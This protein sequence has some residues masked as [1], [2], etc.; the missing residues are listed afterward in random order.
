MFF[1]YKVDNSVI[2]VSNSSAPT[3]AL[4]RAFRIFIT[5]QF[6]YLMARQNSI[7][8]F[9]GKLGNMIGYYR[10]GRYLLRS[11]PVS[12]RQTNATRRA[13]QRFG[14]ASKKGALIRS[15]FDSEL[16]IHYDGTHVNR[17]NS[18]LIRAT[19]SSIS[20][21]TGFRFNQHTGIDRFLTIAPVLTQDA[22]LHIP[23]QHLSAGKGITALEVKIIATRISF[24][25]QRVI[26]TNTTT[27]S[28][29]PNRPL[30]ATALSVDVPGTG[31][32]VVVIQVRALRNDGPACNRQ[33]YAADIVG[34]A[35]PQ[36]VHYKNSLAY[37]VHTVSDGQPATNDYLSIPS[38]IPFF[39]QRE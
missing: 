36:P 29:D 18:R 27:I 13:A 19:G 23:A 8:L 30:T 9:T 17:L 16:D 14:I 26:D 15:V 12:V 35:E 5:H 34:I 11:A 10:K 22:T 38:T 7:L 21:V 39:I 6:Y 1:I 25:T 31:T 4:F 2:P 37:Q 24:A 20:A 32:L 33:N 3:K 28:I